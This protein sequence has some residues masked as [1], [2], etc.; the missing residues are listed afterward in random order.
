MFQMESNQLTT[1]FN[2]IL[3]IPSLIT[4]AIIFCLLSIKRSRALLWENFLISGLIVALAS[5]NLLEVITFGNLIGNFSLL[6]KPYYAIAIISCSFFLCLSWRLN[7]PSES[8]Q[9]TF[10]LVVILANLVVLPLILFTD[11]II[12]GAVRTSYTVSRVPGD[13]YWI[14]QIYS[15]VCILVGMIL[16]WRS[17][18]RA[19]NPL[20]KKRHIV[21]FYSFLPIVITGISVLIL[22]Q[23]GFDINFSIFL[24]LSTLLFVIVYLFT[25]NRSDLFKFLVNIPYSEERAAYKEVNDRLI[26]YLARTQTDEKISLKEAM[27]SIEK[28][29]IARALELKGGDHNLAAE[30]LSISMSTIYRKEDKSAANDAK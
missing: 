26:E 14:F 19:N 25:E 30:M 15:L 28:A 17:Y 20:D 23:L 3:A 24:P 2:V 5:M 11:A 16:I 22:M 10:Y 6:I 27:G 7:S 1:E 21:I 9:R 29:F 13:Q 18:A 4:L 12:N 8:T